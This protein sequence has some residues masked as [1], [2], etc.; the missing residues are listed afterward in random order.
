MKKH[1]RRILVVAIIVM[2]LLVVYNYGLHEQLNLENIKH[3]KDQLLALYQNHPIKTI[4]VFSFV[5]VLS[6]ALSIPGAA[7]LTLLGGSLF[8]V[9]LGTIIVSFTSTLGATLAFLTSRFIIRESIEKRFNDRLTLINTG[10]K[11]EGAFYLFSLRLIPI[12][13]FVV[14]NLVM[15]LTQMKT[16]T[17]YWVSQIGMLA[18]TIVYVNAGTQL[19][20][21]NELKHVLSPVLIGSFV[22]LGLLPLGLNKLLPVFKKYF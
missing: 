14:I 12:F 10:I 20:K 16:W 11:K 4:L 22:A 8:G 18:G 9:L 15:G 7:L 19:S 13:P 5:Y 6:T 21:I 1:H 2:V 3:K 17:F